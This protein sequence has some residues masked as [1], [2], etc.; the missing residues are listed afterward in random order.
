MIWMVLFACSGK[1]TGDTGQASVDSGMEE[2]VACDDGWNAWA[3]GFFTTYCTSCHH[4]ES[5]NRHGAPVGIDF[6]TQS[7]TLV[8]LQRVRARVLASQDMPVG[9]GVPV[10]DLQRLEEWMDCTEA[11]R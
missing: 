9:G 8:L 11:Q 1:P 6:H 2:T 10:E 5:V 3:A 7:D 4:P